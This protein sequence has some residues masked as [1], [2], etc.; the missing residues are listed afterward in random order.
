MASA[1]VRRWRITGILSST[2]LP[3]RMATNGCVGRSRMAPR[4]RSSFSIRKPATAGGY[5]GTPTAEGGEILGHADRGGVCAV[6]RAEGVVDVDVGER[7][8]L[9][10]EGRIVGLLLGVE[11]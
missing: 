9:A 8:Q 11:A 7:G 3:P 1:L 5:W 2:F 6:R 4:C 10:G